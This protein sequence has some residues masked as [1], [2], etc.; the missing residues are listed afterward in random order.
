MNHAYNTDAIAKSYE[1]FLNSQDGH[2]FRDQVGKAILT[3]VTDSVQSISKPS[4]LRILDAGCGDGWLAGLLASTTIEQWG[5]EAMELYAC[6]AGAPLIEAAKAKY[7]GVTFTVCD[8]NRPLPYQEHSFDIVTAS[9]VLHDVEDEL[10]TMQNIHSVLKPGGKLIAAIVNPYY[11]YPIGEWKRGFW[12][13]LFRKKPRLRLA[14]SYNEMLAKN[15]PSFQWRPN[16]GSHFTPLS[17]HMQNAKQAGFALTNLVDLRSETD[18]NNY[19]LT[20]QLH[21]FP[22]ILLLEFTKL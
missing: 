12:R 2:I 5:N 18:S 13:R 11:G 9:M 17:V 16:L 10:A 15:R 22:T 1:D 4:T 14:R 8:L 7:P 3:A 20:Y 21:R 19:N 6:D